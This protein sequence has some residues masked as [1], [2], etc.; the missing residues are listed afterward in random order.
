MISATFRA[1]AQLPR[2]QRLPAYLRCAVAPLEAAGGVRRVT[3]EVGGRPVGVVPPSRRRSPLVISRCSGGP[4][5]PSPTSRIEQS[6]AAIDG[7]IYVAGGID[8]AGHDPSRRSR[9]STRRRGR[10]RSCRRSRAT[11]PL[12]SRRSMAAWLSGGE[13]LAEACS[14][15]PVVFDPA[16]QRW[17]TLAPM[18]GP[19]SQH[20]M[21]GP[22]GE[23]ATS[24]AARSPGR[25]TARCGPSTLRPA[26][27]GPT[28]PE[29]PDRAEPS[30]GRRGRRA[31]LRGGGRS[32]LG[33][34]RT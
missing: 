9:R 33:S 7:V 26:K 24:S 34:S 5:P 18:P 25:A 16:A 6:A 28:L 12:G 27:C 2:L 1:A 14:A 15:R 20:G 8:D 13:V 29:I 11:R 19:R 4:R 23:A 3:V 31:A 17:S 30:L 21:A 22:R 32:R 10:G